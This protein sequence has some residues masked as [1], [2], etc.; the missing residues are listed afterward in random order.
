MASNTP[1]KEA[2]TAHKRSPRLLPKWTT[3]KSRAALEAVYREGGLKIRNMMLR[4]R[5]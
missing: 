5:K 1:I 2:L 4:K 3:L